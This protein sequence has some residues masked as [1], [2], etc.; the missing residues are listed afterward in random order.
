VIAILEQSLAGL[1]SQYGIYSEKQI[2]GDVEENIIS[3]LDSIP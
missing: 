1:H 3:Y 2:K